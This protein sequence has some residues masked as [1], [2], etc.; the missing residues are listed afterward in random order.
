[1]AKFCK[2]SN[3]DRIFGL[4]K[5]RFIG[6]RMIWRWKA[7]ENA[8]PFHLESFTN[9]KWFNVFEKGQSSSEYMCVHFLTACRN[10]AKDMEL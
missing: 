1:M 10:V 6:M 9:S 3:R 7:D 8:L 2:P 4:I 5:K